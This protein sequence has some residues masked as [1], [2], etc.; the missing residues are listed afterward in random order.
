MLGCLVFI[1]TGYPTLYGLARWSHQVIHRRMQT[2]DVHGHA[3]TSLHEVEAGDGKWSP[4]PGLCAFVFTPLRFIERAGWYV[5]EPEGK[6]FGL[7]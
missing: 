5:I 4:L 1:S 7:P 3:V 2:S 6:P